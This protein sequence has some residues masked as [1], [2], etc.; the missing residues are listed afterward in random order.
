[1][2]DILFRGSRNIFAN[3]SQ[4]ENQFTNG[5]FAILE[6]STY[7]D[8]QFPRQFIWDLL[9]VDFRQG[10]ES[11]KVL[12]E[13]SPKGRGRNTDGS[14]ITVDA[15]IAGEGVSL[16]F[17]TKI[18][19]YTLEEVQI[20]RHIK[21]AVCPCDSKVKKLVLLTPDDTGGDFI[22]RIIR[23]DRQFIIHLRWT[24]VRDYL[25]KQSARWKDSVLGKLV[26][27][28]LDVINWTIVNQDYIGIIQKVA[29]NK[30]TGLECP[31]DCREGLM[32]PE[33]WGLSKKRKELD[34]SKGRKLLIYS[35]DPKAILYEAE[36]VGCKE[37]EQTEPDFP[38]RYQIRVGS[39][40]E[41]DP[42]IP[43][44]KIEELQRFKGFGKRQ[45]PYS[46][47]LRSERQETAGSWHYDVVMI[48]KNIVF[49]WNANSWTCKPSLRTGR[50]MPAALGS[51][52]CLSPRPKDE[53][54]TGGGGVEGV[55]ALPVLGVGTEERWDGAG[56]TRCK[57][58]QD[59]RL[60]AFPP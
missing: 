59:A 12:R 40:V 30:K 13:M 37:D 20:E 1:M 15:K 19:S 41:F 53:E 45:A 50:P 58:Q 7:Q 39:V 14:G 57:L 44:T 3:Y 29:F 9:E 2:A 34:G 48:S 25:A 4:G 5:L 46:N 22:Q 33:G 31:D 18:K 43:L 26:E 35:S 60:R 11:F 52:F 8:R 24:Q 10:I 56:F 16:F 47:L 23:K 42:P 55:M 51:Q 54:R 38:W 27:E 36:V 28:Y 21:T 6:L 32:H 17:E 49:L